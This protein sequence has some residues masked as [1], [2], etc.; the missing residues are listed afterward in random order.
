MDY[1]V[2]DKIM[3]KRDYHNPEFSYK[4][5]LVEIFDDIT[6]PLFK[7]NEFYTVTNDTEKLIYY[8]NLSEEEVKTYIEVNKKFI[9]RKYFYTN[10][11]LRK[12]KLDQIDKKNCK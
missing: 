9:E 8:D 6:I 10:Q 5:D 12:K 2:G 7:E 11:E 4:N 3:C 1:K